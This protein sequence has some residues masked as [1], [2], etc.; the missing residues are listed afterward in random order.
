MVILRTLSPWHYIAMKKSE[1][2][3]QQAAEEE[4]DLK[5]LGL[6]TGS[7]RE[8]RLEKFTET[9]LPQLLKAGYDISEDVWTYRYTIDTSTGGKNYG[10]VDYYPKANNLL[11]RKTNK[12]IKP[13]LR[14]IVEKL[15]PNDRA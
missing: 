10:I 15:L 4:N 12:W 3:K 5:A 1:A 2:L 14:W 7:L 13:G 9:Y 6:M 11:I 8:G